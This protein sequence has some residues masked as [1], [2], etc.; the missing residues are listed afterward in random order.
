[1]ITIALDE[2]GN[3]EGLYDEKK[4]G[5]PI[6]IGGL[7]FDELGD[8]KEYDNERKKISFY[9]QGI[10]EE[11]GGRYPSSLHS[12]GKNNAEVAKAKTLITETLPEF[13]QT[14]RSKKIA[15]PYASYL[16]KEP[17]RQGKYYF[18]A[19][20]ICD[21]GSHASQEGQSIIVRE[22]YA[23]NLYMHMAENIVERLIFHNPIVKEIK[24]VHLELATR[25]VKVRQ[26]KYREYR[27]L[28]YVED[29]RKEHYKDG[30]YTFFLTTGDNYR[31]A[32]DREMQDTEKWDIKFDAVVAKS[33]FYG[34]STDKAKMEFLYMADIVCSVLGFQTKSENASELVWELKKRADFYTGHNENLIF[35]H[36]GVDI[37]FRKA[38][39]KFEDK[40]YY[41]ALCLAYE[42]VH[43]DSPFADYYKHIWF[44]CLE[45][46]LREEDS[47]LHYKIALEK[48]YNSTRQ[49][50][51]N[52][53]ELFYIFS[54]LKQMKENMRFANDEEKAVLYKLYDTG[55]SAYC[56]IGQ[57]KKAVRYFEKCQE[58]ASYV[59]IE[60]YIRTRNK[61]SVCLSDAFYFE[62]AKKLAEE[63]RE[64]CEKLIPLRSFILKTN[65]EKM[66][67]YGI[68]C[69][70]LGQAYAFLRDKK[71]E[72]VFRQSLEQMPDVNSPNYLITLSYLLHFYLDMG[73]KE[74]YEQMAEVY[75]NGNPD[76]QSQLY[77]ILEEA[78]KGRQGR[79][80]MKFALYVF[81]R[82]VYQFYMGDVKE[83]GIGEQIIQIEEAISNE[84]EEAKKQLVGHPW[85][86]IYKYLAL[87]AYDIGK[88]EEAQKFIAKITKAVSNQGMIIDMICW[89]GQIEYY[90]HTGD[91]MQ[92]RQ[93]LAQPPE[94]L[95][96]DNPV[97]ELLQDK[98]DFQKLYDKLN[99]T[100]FTFMYR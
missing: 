9:L 17:E 54:V 77:Y 35:V 3:F 65:T 100:V 19:N 14:G 96:E 61:L 37:G 95:E 85:E 66:T 98:R 55:V 39:A 28:G 32:I 72:E 18:F 15:Q 74:E 60:T 88:T 45:E 63:N 62:D 83:I 56:H 82:S 76:L 71:A 84:G 43:K 29:K 12:N 6:F 68:T 11:I 21:D 22:D 44:S 2:Q 16:N 40:D 75:F 51:L 34:V 33:I 92:A 70:Q 23:G 93:L 53:E 30:E 67:E 57:A 99:N 64:Y 50:N 90:I 47:L 7:V 78:S 48:L 87:I 24:R 13:L 10:C 59:G 46:R 69:S 49:N 80:S 97:Y 41:E 58:Y 79:V 36:D 20:M 31:T 26:D 42:T 81:V 86:I 52:Q 27:R 5:A 94:S 8:D 38:W 25:V 73:M 1:M 4:T 91:R 89:F